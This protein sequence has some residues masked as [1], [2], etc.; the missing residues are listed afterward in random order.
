MTEMNDQQ[1]PTTFLNEIQ[2]NLY[3]VDAGEIADLR[4][5]PYA[6]FLNS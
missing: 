1:K 2:S 6:L 5:I 3:E 4:E